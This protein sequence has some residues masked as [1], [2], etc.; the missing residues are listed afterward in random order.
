MNEQFSRPGFR[1]RYEHSID[2]KGRLALPSRYRKVFDTYYQPPDVYLTTD[3]NN[4]LLVYPLEVWSSIEDEW[5]AFSRYDRDVKD[6]LFISS[7]FGLECSVDGTGRLLIPKSMRDATGLQGDVVIIGKIN[8]F[9]IW[10]RAKAEQHVRD[11]LNKKNSEDRLAEIGLKIKQV[12]TIGV[13]GRGP[14]GEER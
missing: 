10:D 12:G 3:D 11:L 1:G 4:T 8:H 2:L 13:S 7:Y 6:Q 9:E 14:T 5:V